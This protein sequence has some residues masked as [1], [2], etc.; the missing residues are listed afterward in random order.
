MEFNWKQFIE[1]LRLKEKFQVEAITE[2]S[3]TSFVNQKFNIQINDEQL[4]EVQKKFSSFKKKF[5]RSWKT[6]RRIWF[7]VYEKNSSWLEEGHLLSKPSQKRKGRPEKTFAEMKQR[8][9]RMAVAKVLENSENDPGLLLQA[10]SQCASKLKRGNLNRVIKQVSAY[11]HDEKYLKDFNKL[12]SPQVIDDDKAVALMIDAKMSVLDYKKTRNIVNSNGA[13]ILPGYEKVKVAKNKCRPESIEITESLANISWQNLLTHTIKRIVELC[14]DEIEKEFGSYTGII[15]MQFLGT[16]GYD[17]SSGHTTHQ[18]NVQEASVA[19]CSLFSTHMVPISLK[20]VDGKRFWLNESPS[21]ASWCR[22]K[23]YELVKESK[24]HVLK[25]FKGN[26]EEIKSL[27][28][29][30]VPLKS[31]EV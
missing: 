21:S 14:E 4:K 31:G 15:P 7:K 13:K 5:I 29:I 27:E 11:Q 16:Y 22:P 8:A 24:Q 18:Q 1:F 9:K 3:F 6:E 10:A 2:A 26:E 30:V 19:T 20:A 28:P 17:G 23:K 12:K 25:E